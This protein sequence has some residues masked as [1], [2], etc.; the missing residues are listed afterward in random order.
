MLIPALTWISLG[1]ICSPS[2]TFLPV[3]F[4]N[5]NQNSPVFCL[6]FETASGSMISHKGLLCR[7]LCISSAP[8]SPS[9]SSC[10][11]LGGAAGVSIAATLRG[12]GSNAVLLTLLGLWGLT[13][14]LGEAAQTGRASQTGEKLFVAE[15]GTW[16]P[17]RC[18]WKCPP[19]ACGS[20]ACDTSAVCWAQYLVLKVN[21]GA[22]VLC[23][24]S[25]LC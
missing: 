12:E 14:D 5:H 22:P 2:N 3:F 19:P 8:Q 17:D 24:I 15:A 18:L 6:R 20:S 11:A 13:G 7:G 4:L 23:Y 1:E 25:C 10:K 16:T 21:P 9:P